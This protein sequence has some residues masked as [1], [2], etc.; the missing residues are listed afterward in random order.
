VTIRWLGAALMAF[1]F[2]AD[3]EEA[4]E[5]LKLASLPIE[6]TAFKPTLHGTFNGVDLRLL[7]DSGAMTTVLFPSGVQKA[8]LEAI[9]SN[10]VSLGVGGAANN[11]IAVAKDAQIGPSRGNNVHFLAV[12]NT[13]LSGDGV[14]GADYLFRTDVEVLLREN[15][16]IFLQAQH[17]D[18]KP[19][20][21]W[22]HDAPWVDSHDVWGSD[23]RQKVEVKINGQRFSALLDSGAMQSMINLRA[24]A[25]IGLKPDSLGTQLVGLVTGIGRQSVPSW[26]AHIDTFEI[27]PETIRN[28]TIQFADLYGAAGHHLDLFEPDMVLGVDF[29]QAHRLLFSRS[30]GRLYFTYLGG[31]IFNP[32][33]SQEELL[34]KAEHLREEAEKNSVPDMLGL[35][36]MLIMGIGVEKD[37]V[38]ACKWLLIAEQSSWAASHPDLQQ[39]IQRVRAE[40]LN[41]LDESEAGEARKR[42]A[43]W[44]ASH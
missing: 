30:Q 11:F 34:K 3:A 10:I 13:K 32:G 7:M 42:A 9:H 1:S 2:S 26:R 19:I 31:Q 12:K 33:P 23:Q 28:I 17:C 14:L 24:A 25:S 39:N 18:D 27:G 37:R 21:Y 4:C 5:V 43:A 6:Y 15:K 8:G 22:D 35:A 16:V 36:D 41:Q 20:S 44:V 38:E 29:M 40:L